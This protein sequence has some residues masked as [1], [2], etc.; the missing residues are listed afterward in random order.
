MTPNEHADRLAPFIV[1]ELLASAGSEAEQ[2]YIVAEISAGRWRLEPWG[3]ATAGE[4]LVVHVGAEDDPRSFE[5][6]TS[7]DPAE[8]AEAMLE[9]IGDDE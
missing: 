2:D 9:D 7:P 6:I 3:S 5:W 8:H 4:L 1:A